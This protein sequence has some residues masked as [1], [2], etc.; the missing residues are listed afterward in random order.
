[1]ITG[2]YAKHTHNTHAASRGNTNTLLLIIIITTT[3][4]PPHTSNG[5]IKHNKT[6]QQLKR[7]RYST[8]NR[9]ARSHLF[10]LLPVGA[11]QQQTSYPPTVMPFKRD[12]HCP[13][14]KNLSER[15]S[16]QNVT[17][18]VITLYLFLYVQIK[19]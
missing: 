6:E 5:D 9:S 16:I 10:V 8:R 19:R 17:L 13:D 7:C 12:T 18:N 11:L 2:L 4:P 3:P 15:G 14:V 1:M